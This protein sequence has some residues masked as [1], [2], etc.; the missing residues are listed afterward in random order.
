MDDLEIRRM[1]NTENI[2]EIPTNRSTNHRLILTL[3]ILLIVALLIVVILTSLLFTYYKSLSGIQ[4]HL[5]NNDKH[6]REEISQMNGSLSSDVQSILAAVRDLEQVQKSNYSAMKTTVTD[7]ENELLM[8]H[9]STYI[10]IAFL[11]SEIQRMLGVLGKVTEE[12]QKTKSSLNLTCST[13]WTHYGLS[14][15]YVSSDTQPW[16]VSKKECEDLNAQLVVI[17]S[18]GEMNYVRGISQ[19]ITDIWIGLTDADG[20]WKWVDG[21]PY[22]ITPDFWENSQPDN[23][24]GHGLGGGEDCVVSRHANKWNDCHCSLSCRYICEKKIF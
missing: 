6:I 8:K 12:V 4:S 23:W 16:N 21:T 15:Y 19:G 17:N 2:K 7:L 11:Y 20:T 24:M 3:W 5:E 13:G 22:D 10:Y 9:T 14:C 1:K 18:E